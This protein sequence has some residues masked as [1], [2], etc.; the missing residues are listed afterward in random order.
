MP[1]NV[2]TIRVVT[3]VFVPIY[4]RVTAASARQDGLV[5]TV[6]HVSYNSI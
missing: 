2:L 1:I 3:A 5:A 4:I 6:T